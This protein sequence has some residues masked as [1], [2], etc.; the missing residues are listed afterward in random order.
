MQAFENGV[1]KPETGLLM[2]LACLARLVVPGCGG[3]QNDGDVPL[4]RWGSGGTVKK[5]S[6][7]PKVLER[8]SRY[9]D[10]PEPRKA[11]GVS[12]PCFDLCEDFINEPLTDAGQSS[13]YCATKKAKAAGP[14][15]RPS[16]SPPKFPNIRR[17]EGS[18]CGC[19]QRASVPLHDG[20][21]SWFGRQMCKDEPHDVTLQCTQQLLASGPWEHGMAEKR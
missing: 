2:S 9:R 14:R 21:W 8:E 16:N 17:T 1:S 10:D 12:A 5:L 3:F 15:L 4:F 19:F 7:L 6:P 11:V 20:W 18:S 13:R